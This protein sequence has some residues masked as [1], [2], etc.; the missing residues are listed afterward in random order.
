MSGAIR[1][2]AATREDVTLLLG[3]IRELAAFERAPD[4]VIASE[5]DLLRDGFGPQPRFEARLA[6]LDDRPVGFALVFT[7]YST[8]K[9]R[10]GLYLEDLFVSEWARGRGV[11]RRLLAD[12]AALAQARGYPRLDLA[13]LDWNPARRF[14][15]RL[16]FEQKP[17]WLGYRLSGAALAA[18]ARQARD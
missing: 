15:Q 8:W 5:A 2:R 12:L 11:A 10:P 3:F 13:V 1:V 4:A 6:L 18:L 14:Y 7:S 16:G 17:E 9:G